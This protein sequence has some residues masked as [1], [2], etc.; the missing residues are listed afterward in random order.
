MNGKFQLFPAT[1]SFYIGYGTAVG[2]LVLIAP[3]KGEGWVAFAV[4]ILL[5]SAAYSIGQRLALKS[6]GK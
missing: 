1:R 4:A 6:E 2:S 5:S 3:L